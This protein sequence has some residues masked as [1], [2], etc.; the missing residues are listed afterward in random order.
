MKRG[1]RFTDAE[2]REMLTEVERRV[3]FL[4]LASKPRYGDIRGGQYC[5]WAKVQR[6]FCKERG[7][8]VRSWEQLIEKRITN[9]ISRYPE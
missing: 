9:A 4:S 5:L 1:R 7:I 6:E 2:L 3:A 8:T